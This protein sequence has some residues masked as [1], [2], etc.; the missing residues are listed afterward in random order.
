M[1]DK[2]QI[3]V[4]CTLLKEI[5]NIANHLDCYV[6]TGATPLAER[7]EIIDKFKNNNKPLL[8]TFG[9]GAFGLNLQFCN[10][11]AFSSI[12]FDYAKVEQ[13]M[14]RI[15]RIGQD[16]DIEYIYF[17]SDLGI[18]NMIYDNLSKKESLNDLLI[19]FIE[20]GVENIE[21]IL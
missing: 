20:K 15:K 3:I 10:K 18:Y 6:I 11:I 5:E 2:G 14:S 12:T 8:M 16:K 13:S 4:F 9:V 21:K 17:K 7:Q 19:K 1:K